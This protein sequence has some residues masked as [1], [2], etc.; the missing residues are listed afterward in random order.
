M[1]QAQRKFPLFPALW[2]TKVLLTQS[3]ELNWE[4]L[5]IFRQR[6]KGRLIIDNVIMLTNP[7]MSWIQWAEAFSPPEPPVNII[8]NET[9]LCDEQTIFSL[10]KIILFG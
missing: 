7:F 1:N 5:T 10:I 9:N 8:H 6:M 3:T 2:T 4:T